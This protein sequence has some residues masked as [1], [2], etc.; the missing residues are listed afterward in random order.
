MHQTVPMN[1]PY[2]GSLLYIFSNHSKLQ[3]Y[4]TDEYINLNEHVLEVEKLKKASKQW[5]SSEKFILKLAFH[6]YGIPNK[7][8]LNDIDYLDQQN[9][10]LVMEAI[11]I[12][13]KG[14]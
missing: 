13:F 7:L 2:L 14:I 8:D 6:L 12:R 1:D 5:S 3:N 9:K 11:K 10:R 4:L